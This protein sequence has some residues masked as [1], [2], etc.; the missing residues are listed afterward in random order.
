MKSP[1]S[2][3]TLPI[4]VLLAL[5]GGTGFLLYRFHQSDLK[6]LSE[7]SA[8]CASF[9][10]AIGALSDSAA[11]GHAA[12]GRVEETLLDLKAKAARFNLSSLVE[13]DARLMEE[14]PRIADLSG[15][16]W[17]GLRAYETAVLGKSAGVDTLA[18]TYREFA[19]QRKA[20]VARF[21][22]LLESNN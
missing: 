5:I 7:F 11:G 8:A 18:R 15:R 17:A 10:E 20:A 3:L 19:A 21:H 2:R 9:D 12:G 4:L 14:A 6:T 22:R 1:M 16:E 13:D